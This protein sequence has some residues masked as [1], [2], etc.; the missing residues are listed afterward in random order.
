MNKQR[1]NIAKS[2]I[3]INTDWWIAAVSFIKKNKIKDKQTNK[4]L[5]FM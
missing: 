1:N 3:F 4:K 5:L 2:N